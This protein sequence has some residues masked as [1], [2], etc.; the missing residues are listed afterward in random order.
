[1][2][3]I[4]DIPVQIPQG[5]AQ[6]EAV[7]DSQLTIPAWGPLEVS[8]QV[9]L[10]WSAFGGFTPARMNGLVNTLRAY[11]ISGGWSAKPISFSEVRVICEFTRWSE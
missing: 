2:V 6:V 11:E 7:I 3:R 1:M 9:I 10:Q 4:A 8:R 5:F